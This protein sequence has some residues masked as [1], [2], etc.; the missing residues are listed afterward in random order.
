[1][2]IAAKHVSNQK[3]KAAL[4]ASTVKLKGNDVI[5]TW[6]VLVGVWITPPLYGFWMGVAEWWAWRW[7]VE[8]QFQ[9][10][11]LMDN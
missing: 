8:F 1:M 10:K 5:A 9:K 2:F 6:K 7:V 4:A 3:A 11:Q